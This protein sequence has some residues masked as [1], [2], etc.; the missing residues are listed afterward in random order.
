[1]PVK[2]K[3]VLLPYDFDTAIGINNEGSLVFSYNLEDTDTVDDAEVYNGQD[4]VLWNNLR[5]TFARELRA[6]Y[7]DLRSQGII[8]YDNVERMFEEHQ[9]KW[10]AAL[11]NEDS[12]YK[13]IDPLRND[14]DDSYLSMMQGDKAEQ[15][16]WW[17]NNRFRY[18]DSKYNAGDALTDVITLRGYAKAN[19]SVTPYADIYP[20]I[21]YGSYL[22][23][24]RGS[25]GNP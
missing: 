11:F 6:M 8:S 13:Y 19:I 9:A 25:R 3:I 21:R 14:G 23:S 22:V 1:M 2:K 10:P 4:S 24:E 5:K 16:K 20:T 18:I 12:W 15:R 17:L 7:R